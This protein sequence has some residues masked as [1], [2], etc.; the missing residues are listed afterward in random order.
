MGSEPRLRLTQPAHAQLHHLNSHRIEELRREA[1][2][3]VER[4]ASLR[5]DLDDL[6]RGIEA[7]PKDE[8]IGQVVEAFKAATA[9]F[10]ALSSEA[11]A[12]LMRRLL[13]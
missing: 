5:Q 10:S 9:R 4:H 2:V 1:T 11:E 3:L 7:A 12:I 8:E 13:P 6:E